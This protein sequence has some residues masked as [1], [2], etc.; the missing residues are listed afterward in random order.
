MR[1]KAF[2][3]FPFFLNFPVPPTGPGLLNLRII[4]SSVM[5]RVF[6]NR[7]SPLRYYPWTFFSF[8][9]ELLPSY[10]AG[11]ERYLLSYRP[12]SF[13]FLHF[14][15]LYLLTSVFRFMGLIFSPVGPSGVKTPGQ[16]N[17]CPIYAEP[18][19]DHAF[20]DPPLVLRR[21]MWNGTPCDQGSYLSLPGIWSFQ[22]L[23]HSSKGHASI[24]T[25]SFP[26]LSGISPPLYFPLDAFPLAS[27]FLKARLRDAER[28]F[29][30]AGCRLVSFAR[31]VPSPPVFHVVPKVP[32]RFQAGA[33]QTF[34]VVG[35]LTCKLSF[36]G[37]GA[38]PPRLALVL[39]G[40]G[41]HRAPFFHGPT[42]T[43]LGPR[44]LDFNSGGIIFVPS[45]SHEKPSRCSSSHRMLNLFFGV[46][47]SLFEP[48]EDHRRKDSEGTPW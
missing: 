25:M 22:N 31:V 10:V 28:F 19:P 37:I 33:T 48:G 18:F 21:Y 8:L 30:E 4:S 36:A 42:G 34:S 9:F 14:M 3:G 35:T 15:R 7:V 26:P 16:T 45:Q 32:G 38:P 23:L 20:L 29:L 11:G 6:Q 24:R 40:H 47:F 17:Y 12:L 1:R 13:L 46:F 27:I 2:G 39:D 41:A 44:L 5:V 43:S